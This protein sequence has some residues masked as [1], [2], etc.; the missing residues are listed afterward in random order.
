MHQ[1]AMLQNKIHEASLVHPLERTSA[2]LRFMLGNPEK[3][4]LIRLD[5]IW[6][7]AEREAYYSNQS[8]TSVD[9]CSMAEEDP[10]ALDDLNSKRSALELLAGYGSDSDSD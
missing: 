5:C 9:N 6:T 8:R 10:H 3:W 1:F 2:S 7:E 4:R